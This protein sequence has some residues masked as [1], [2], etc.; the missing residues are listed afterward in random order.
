MRNPVHRFCIALLVAVASSASTHANEE[1]LYPNRTVR[2]VVSAP[3]GGG[4]DTT[5]RIFA[6]Q[7]QQKWKQ[8]VIIENRP[9]ASGNLAAE[10]VAAAPP[11][12]YTLLVAMPPPF[13]INKILY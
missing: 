13:T 2:I 6:D 5:A 9:G 3:P 4:V 10:A 12:G 7:L 11:D 8:P 1:S